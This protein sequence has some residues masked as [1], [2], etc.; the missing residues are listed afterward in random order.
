VDCTDVVNM[1][2]RLLVQMC[3]SIPTVIYE[4]LS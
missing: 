1:P 4:V 3:S 2:C